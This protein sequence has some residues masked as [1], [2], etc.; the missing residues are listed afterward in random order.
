MDEHIKTLKNENKG[1]KMKKDCFGYK[2]TNGKETCRALTKIDCKGCRFYK[3]NEQ[4][5]K[6]REAAGLLVLA[7]PSEQ[8]KGISEKYGVNF[9]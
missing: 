7:L 2:N 6:D 8:R 3:S 1:V 4:A 5:K 9:Y